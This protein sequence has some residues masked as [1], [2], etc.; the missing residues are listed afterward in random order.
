MTEYRYYCNWCEHDLKDSSGRVSYEE[1]DDRDHDSNGACSRC[2]P[3]FYEPCDHDWQLDG[4][5]WMSHSPGT[6]IDD[7]G[8]TVYHETCSKCPMGRVTVA[9]S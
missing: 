5:V 1:Y 4:S 2:D 8:N 6:G 7:D 9:G 3:S